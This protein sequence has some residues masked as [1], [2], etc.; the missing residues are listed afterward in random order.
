[1]RTWRAHNP[2]FEIMCWDERNVPDDPF[3]HR[4][5]AEGQWSRA[6]NAVRLHALMTHGGIYL[7]TDVEVLNP[8][9]PF[10][11]LGCFLGFQYQPDGTGS[12]PFEA[13]VDGAVVGATAGHPLIEKFHAEI[14]RHIE[15]PAAFD[16]M[17]PVMLTGVLMREGLSAYSETPVRVGGAMIFP[18]DVF[19]PY[20]DRETRP[21]TV[22]PETFAMHLWAKRW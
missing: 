5:L 21:A 3:V 22:G 9:Y 11:D 19:Y 1:M 20:F 10:L 16:I 12:K 15:G 17:G 14:P 6:S 18:K 13:C 8:F 7:D 4:A 2:D